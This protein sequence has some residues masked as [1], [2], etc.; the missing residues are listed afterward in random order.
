V[1]TD[2]QTVGWQINSISY[3]S[4][5]WKLYQRGCFTFCWRVS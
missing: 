4:E 2:Q 3:D 1:K 5:R